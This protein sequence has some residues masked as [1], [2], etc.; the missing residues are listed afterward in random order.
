MFSGH[1]PE[2]PFE[3]P[4]PGFDRVRKN[5]HRDVVKFLQKAMEVDHRKRFADASQMFAAFRRIRTRALRSTPARRRRRKDADATRRDWR[6]IRQSDFL[7]RYRNTLEIDGACHRCHGPVSQAMQVCPWCGT[8]RRMTPGETKFRGRCPRCKRG[9]KTDWR[10]CP[11]CYGAAINAGSVRRFSDARYN[12]HCSNG[13]CEG[14]LLMPFMCYCPWCRRK[15]TKAWK[16]DDSKDRC[17]RCA[18]GV[19]PDYWDWCPWCAR[20]IRRR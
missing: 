10:F 11:W 16:I 1:L 13:S 18:W 20:T 4:P 17:P 19:L 9:T 2:W 3:W 14:K 6:T 5:L 12:A 8:K 15:V 7:K